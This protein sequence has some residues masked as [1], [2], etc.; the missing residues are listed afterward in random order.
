MPKNLVKNMGVYKIT[1]GGMTV[2]LSIQPPTLKVTHIAATR[3]PAKPPP[4][5]TWMLAVGP[6]RKDA[7]KGSNI[8]LQSPS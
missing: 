8:G 4:K 1:H 7:H 3:L 2:R 5:I 6:I